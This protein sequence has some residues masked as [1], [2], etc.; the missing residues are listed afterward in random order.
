MWRDTREARLRRY[1]KILERGPWPAGC[2]DAQQDVDVSGAG[3]ESPDRSI[4]AEDIPEKNIP[5]KNMPGKNPPERGLN[6]TE[7]F[8]DALQA[9]RYPCGA[10]EKIERQPHTDGRQ[11]TGTAMKAADKTRTAMEAANKTGMAMD[12]A[13][14]EERRKTFEDVCGHVLAP[15]LNGFVLWVLKEA[16]RSGKR[17]LYFL[18]R[19]GYLMYRAA[20]VYCEKWK[21]PLECRYLSCSRY[22]IR[23]PMFHLD[24]DGALGYICRGGIDV[25]M[26]KI[27]NR[28][29][30]TETE[31]EKLLERLDIGYGKDDAVPYAELAGIGRKLGQDAWFMRCVKRHSEDAMPNLEGY[32]M[33]EGLF[34]G[35]PA[36]LVDSGWVGSMQKVLNQLTAYIREKNKITGQAHLEGYY[37]G[38]YELP[39]GVNPEDYHCYYFSPGGNLREKI[40]FSNCLFEG[41]FSAPHGMTMGYVEEEAAEDGNGGMD[42]QHLSRLP[43]SEAESPDLSVESLKLPGDGRKRYRPVY[44][45]I[46]DPQKEFMEQTEQRL[47]AYTEGL[48]EALYRTDTDDIED[49]HA[50]NFGKYFDRVDLQ[51]GRETVSRLL[52]LFM[53]EPTAL[54][55]EV[56]GSIPFSDDVLDYGGRQ[57]AE[58]MT[59][60][61]LTANHLWHKALAMLGIRKKH[62][63]ESAWYEGSAVRSG[64]HVKRHLRRYAGY[65]RLLYLRKKYQMRNVSLPGKK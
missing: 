20:S 56:Y 14:M 63:K 51:C 1:R 39:E 32:L 18:A 27:L 57:M 16:L 40:Y 13:E 64:E 60:E 21:L 7:K 22:S 45:E 5:G 29:G 55:A 6:I 48:A 17:R 38:L 53:G 46:S 2:P 15:A 47:M 26:T 59:Q 44:G 54:E 49:G 23:I 31:K 3:K 25:T 9:E 30:L 36:A 28:A 8:T 19:D 61:E 35:T 52:E 10:D 12:M 34:D 50:G 11:E 33:Q 58:P 4:P 24:M 62:V 65:K 43:D 42:T 37:W 41:I